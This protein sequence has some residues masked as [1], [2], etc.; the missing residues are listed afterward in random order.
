MLIQGGFL[1]TLNVFPNVYKRLQLS[2]YKMISPK[3]VLMADCC[4]YPDT[5]TLI[6]DKKEFVLRAR[7]SLQNKRLF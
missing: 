5:P 4:G 1:L 7:I 6:G 2:C 3:M